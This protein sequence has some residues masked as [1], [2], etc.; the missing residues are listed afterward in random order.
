MEHVLH[1]DV[2]GPRRVLLRLLD[3]LVDKHVDKSQGERQPP[4]LAVPHELT[5]RSFEKWSNRSALDVSQVFRDCKL[6]SEKRRFCLTV[7]TSGFE[8]GAGPRGTEPFGFGIRIS[9]RFLVPTW[10][11]EM[12]VEDKSHSF[13]N[14]I[15][16]MET[17]TGWSHGCSHFYQG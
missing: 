4:L 14:G 15:R 8:F 17:T 16:S 6:R 11:E 7:P 9:R 12:A 5:P 1:A 10:Q 13:V 2:P 3:E